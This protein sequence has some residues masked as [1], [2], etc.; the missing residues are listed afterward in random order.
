MQEGKT[1]FD[2]I[3][4][5]T[6]F[7]TK[8]LPFKND[9]RA[10]IQKVKAVHAAAGID[11]P[12]LDSDDEIADIDPF[13]VFGT[14]SKKIKDVNRIALLQ[15]I[16]KEFDVSAEM[17][18]DFRGVP[19][20]NNR[21]AAFY[22]FKDDKNRKPDDIDNLWKLFAAA[23]ALADDDTEEKRQNFS[24]TYDKV[25]DQYRIKW[26]I[27]MGLYWVRPYTFLNLDARNREFIMQAQHMPRGFVEMAQKK[28]KEPPSAADY[29]AIKDSCQKVLDAG[30][31]EY[32]NFPELSYAAWLA[33]EEEETPEEISVPHR[34]LYTPGEDG[35]KWE[36]CYA[37][38]YMLLGWGK[39]G[40]LAEF[41]TKDDMKQQL[42]QAYGDGSTYRDEGH[43]TWQFVHDLKIGDIIFVKEGIHGILGKG[44]VESD[45]EYDGNREDDYS[46]IR[47][48]KWTHKGKWKLKNWVT[49]KTLTDITV[50]KYSKYVEEIESLFTGSAPAPA[51][52]P[53]PAPAPAKLA[54][55]AEDFLRDVY[56]SEEDYHHLV[57]LLTYKKNV[58]LQG[59]PGVG[60]TFAAKRLAYSM[61]GVKD[62]E[63]VMMVQFHQSYSYEDFIMG[64]RPTAAGFELRTGAFYDFCKKAE[65]DEGRDYFFIIDE[66]NRGNLSKIFGELFM[67]IET[68][69]RGEKVRLLYSGEEFAVPKNVHLIGMMNTAD[70]SL[71]MLDYAL[72]RRFVFFDI[73]PGFAAEGFRKYQAAV[74]N[75][76]FDKLIACVESLNGEIA[77]D[78]SLGEGFTIGHSYFC[79]DK[80]ETINDEWLYRVVEYELIPLLKEYWYDESSKVEAW[81]ERLRGAI[82]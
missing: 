12:K 45:Y 49:K 25:H 67:L 56:M 39:I 43:A 82:R 68:D 1:I 62:K 19:I 31:Y 28:L 71:A 7:A 24:E 47:K 51:P 34:W 15:S 23:L 44:I 36:E 46:N 14:F 58:I 10:L 52:E 21:G 11:L 75:T 72:R 9:R 65:A 61:L 3:D 35:D 4:F 13:T 78:D 69:K 55:T 27:T 17:P 77:G 73:K 33:Y 18:E 41:E 42:R 48:V 38:G 26:N 60:K 16:A 40:N 81:S 53:A 6:E 29:L 8:L 66:I 74:G 64:F 30:V 2:W 37:N 63:R 22:G 80:P 32:K 59:P 50:P 5:Y 79:N 57:G 54:Y 70:R 20:L 76:K